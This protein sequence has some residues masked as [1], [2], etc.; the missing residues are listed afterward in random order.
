M[1][2]KL[3]TKFIAGL[4][5][6]GLL[7]SGYAQTPVQ[8]HGKLSTS[9]PYLLNEHGQIV[10]LR[11]MSFFWSRSDWGGTQFYTRDWVKFLKDE[12][13]CT[14]VRAAYDRNEG[15]NNGWNEVKTV[16][17]AA[18]AE[19]IYVIIDWHSHTAHNQQSAAV[20]FFAEQAR[21]YKNTPNVIF[22]PYNEPIVAGSAKQNDGSLENAKET[23]KAIKPYLK[24]VTKAI[25]NEGAENLVILGTPYFA[26]HTGVAANDQ[27]VDDDG[28][29]FKNVAYAFHFYAAS[30][31]PNAYYVKQGDGTGGYEPT[32]FTPALGKVPVFVT[33]WGTSHSDGG[34]DGH[35][36][37]DGE[38]TD[39][40][41]NTHINGPYHL[42][43]CNW[44]V[45][46]FQ[47]SSAFSGGSRNPSASGALAKKWISSPAN[48]TWDRPEVSG[49]DGTAKDTVISM[50]GTH[51]AVWY[52]KFWG[53]GVDTLTVPW[54]SKRDKGDI[55]DT[56]NKAVSISNMGE[57]NWIN[58]NIKS[59]AAT[60]FIQMRVLAQNATGEIEIFTG[61]TS[62]GKVV[63]KKDSSW[64]TTVAAVNIPS[65]QQTLKFNFVK[66]T[67]NYWIEWFELTNDETRIVALPSPLYHQDKVEFSIFR[68]GFAAQLPLFH[69]YS[70]YSV[71]SADGRIIRSGSINKST[72]KLNF[73]NMANGICLLKLNR[74]NGSGLIKT[75]IINN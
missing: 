9:G 25:R 34:Q 58:Y 49:K 7:A 70:S 4:M 22:E 44:S 29:P 36:H 59:S 43:H 72:S 15:N 6:G 32:Y 55:R 67:G 61:S 46:D 27:V 75:F 1:S 42:S 39:W 14:V 74:T 38:N 3:L 24:A 30:H 48:D 20:S 60:K 19:G 41:F 66:T 53:A 54:G 47:P 71:L 51:S 23:W 33:E 8:K 2:R 10:Q 18:I 26:Q 13:K 56:K 12:W 69:E 35:N 21:L 68:N 62:A 31:G 50:P 11:G 16:I 64:V 52:N 57:T 73:E 28:K 45:S 37:I 63:I 65:G 40:W 5:I 17:D